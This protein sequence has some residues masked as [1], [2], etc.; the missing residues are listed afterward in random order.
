M[1]DAKEGVGEKGGRRCEEELE[2]KSR[3]KGK[4]GDEGDAVGR[5]EVSWTGSHEK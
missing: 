1:H 4:D 2:K 5:E 3:A